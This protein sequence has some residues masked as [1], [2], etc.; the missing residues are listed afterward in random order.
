MHGNAAE[1]TC[2][3]YDAYPYRADDGREADAMGDKKAVRGGS[4]RDRPNQCRSASRWAYAPWQKVFN[5]GFR[6]IIEMETPV[7]NSTP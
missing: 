5:V 3:N 7:L 4:W 1:W 2:S 6:I